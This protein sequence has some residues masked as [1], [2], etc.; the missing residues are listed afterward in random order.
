[1]AN[2]KIPP[3]PFRHGAAQVEGAELVYMEWGEDGPPLLLLHATGF[4]P[5]LWH[6]LARELSAKYRVIAPYF[7]AHRDCDPYHGGLP[8]PTLAQDVT[9]LCRSLGLSRP[10]VAG[11]SMGGTVAVIAAAACGLDPTAMILIEPIFLPQALYTAPLSVEHHPLASKSINRRNHW[12][13][14]I[15]AKEYLR[16]K[17]L[18]AN[19]DDEML[20][21]YVTYGMEGAPEGGITLACHPKREAGLFMGGMHLDPWP[22]LEKAS[23]P[24]LVVEGGT[25]GNRAYIDLKKAAAMFANAQ[26]LEVPGAGH[27]VPMEKPVET[28]RI[29]M[30]FFGKAARKG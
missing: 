13:S 29:M 30:D 11:H 15:D 14:P 27:L 16:S 18:F 22:L 19:W 25:S 24:V 26:Y 7:C 20:D 6:P 17:A 1:M 8:W 4:S 23:A 21:L 28:T 5:H 2:D 3:T 12:E 9:S 10:L